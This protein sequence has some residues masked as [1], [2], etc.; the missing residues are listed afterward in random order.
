MGVEREIDEF[1]GERGR[2]RGLAEASASSSGSRW[3]VAPA[4]WPDLPPEVLDLLA[5]PVAATTLG[6]PGADSDEG[7]DYPPP[8]ESC[9]VRRG[10]GECLPSF[11]APVAPAR[12]PADGGYAAGESPVPRARRTRRRI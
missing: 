5:T 10:Y 3:Q 4:D 6:I 1:L 7:P 11:L 12:P 2:S 8:T 9:A